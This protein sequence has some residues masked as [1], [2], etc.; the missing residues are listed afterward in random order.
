MTTGAAPGKGPGGIEVCTEWQ[1]SFEAFVRD[2]GPR[3]GPGYSIE[4]KDN[5]GNYDRCNC[6]WATQ[7]QQQRNRRSNR[8][9]QAADPR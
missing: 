2:M 7:L 5:D 1:M 9:T 8:A 4:R 6:V 3:P